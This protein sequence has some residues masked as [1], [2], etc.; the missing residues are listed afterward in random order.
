MKDTIQT[1]DRECFS[2]SSHRTQAQSFVPTYQARS[3]LQ[4]RGIWGLARTWSAIASSFAFLATLFRATSGKCHGFSHGPQHVSPGHL[5]DCVPVS[6][7]HNAQHSLNLTTSSIR[8]QLVYV[9][10]SRHGTQSSCRPSAICCFRMSSSRPQKASTKS[11][12]AL[13]V[14]ASWLS[15]CGGRRRGG[16]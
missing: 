1:L 10:S 7:P 12:Q 8:A 13:E 9:R 5:F 2:K 11:R 16:T 14:P 6:I 3:A 15:G 4:G